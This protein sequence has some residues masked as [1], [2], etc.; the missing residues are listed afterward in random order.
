M[1][2]K[3][4]SCIILKNRT[5]LIPAHSIYGESL[6]LDAKNATDTVSET[7]QDVGTAA[8]GV[9]SWHRQ[10]TGGAHDRRNG[11]KLQQNHS[12]IICQITPCITKHSSKTNYFTERFMVFLSTT[13]SLN[14][15]SMLLVINTCKHTETLQLYTRYWISNKTDGNQLVNNNQNWPKNKVRNIDIKNS[16]SV[17]CYLYLIWFCSCTVY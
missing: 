13:F 12:T 3:Y 17:G 1:I 11:E 5:P 8:G 7:R 16:N 10:F 2:N 15:V 6:C 14:D 9:T 4:P